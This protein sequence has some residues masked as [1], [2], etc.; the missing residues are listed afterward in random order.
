MA[1]RGMAWGRVGNRRGLVS[2]GGGWAGAVSGGVGVRG[3]G[4]GYSILLLW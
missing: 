2:R 4:W 1:R 3:G